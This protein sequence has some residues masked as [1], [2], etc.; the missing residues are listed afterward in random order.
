[1]VC[2]IGFIGSSRRMFPAGPTARQRAYR[3]AG[4][5]GSKIARMWSGVGECAGTAGWR[6]MTRVLTLLVKTYRCLPILGS[7][8]FATSQNREIDRYQD[9]ASRLSIHDIHFF[10][11]TFPETGTSWAK[12]IFP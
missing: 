8:N 12:H 4:R 1:M 5:R 7:C 9:Q 6:P 11:P 10:L 2:G 3:P